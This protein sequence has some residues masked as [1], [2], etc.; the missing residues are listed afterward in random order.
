[1]PYIYKVTNI[2][3]GK[4]YIGKTMDT[5]QKRWREHCEDYKKDRCEKRPLYSAMKKYGPDNFTVEVVESCDE[6]ALSDRERFWIEYYSSFK[7]GY[8]AT[9]G[10]DG[11]HYIDYDVVVE[12]YLRTGCQQETA[13]LLSIDDGTVRK[14]LRIRCVDTAKSSDVTKKKLSKVVDM[15]SLSGE[16]IKAFSSGSDAA[17]YLFPNK[18]QAQ[19]IGASSHILD[20][21]KNK[22]RSAY[23]FCWGYGTTS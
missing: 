3:N 16:F 21:C 15:F 20:V 9:V 1:M 23:G 11:R 7:N 2:K 12:T 19:I 18:T 6:S 4:V 10:G 22:R 14:I 8:N 5:V 13:D 17:R